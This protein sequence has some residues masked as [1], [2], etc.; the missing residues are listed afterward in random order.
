MEQQVDLFCFPIYTFTVLTRL[1][2]LC[3]M[4]TQL[5]NY[6]RLIFKYLFNFQSFFKVLIENQHLL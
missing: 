5:L 3:F 4:S 6:L 1:L 2:F